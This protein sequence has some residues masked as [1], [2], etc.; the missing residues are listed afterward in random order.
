MK[1]GY[2]LIWKLSGKT[3]KTPLILGSGTL[4]ENKD[5]LVKC[6]KYGAGAVI[7]RSLR[8]E[9]KKRKIFNPAYYI[10]KNYMLN[11]DN[12]NVVPWDYWL[13]KV[14][15]IEKY[16]KF[17][18]S[19]SAR[20]PDDCKKIVSAFEKKNP[21][22]FYEINFS[23]PH[24][25]KLYGEI[26]YADAEKALRYAKEETSCPVFLKLSLENINIGKL[27]FFEKEKLID[28]LVL[29]NSIGHGM[30]IDI[31]NKKPYLESV[32]GGMSGKAIKL[33]VLAAIYELK[34]R[35]NTPIIGV[36]GIENAEDVI[37]YIILGCDAVQIYTKA[38][39]DGLE[40]FSKISK[41]LEK[42]FLE[43]KVKNIEELKGTLW[44]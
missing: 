30:K 14:E 23:C 5:N 19:I 32:V 43:M 15:E 18:A 22:S 40:I 13:D 41:D 33:L 24:S 35:L 6:L 34:Q 7:N 2:V 36:G 25:A 21:P 31:K 20:N 28:A 1:T 37:E 16:G 27:L 26:S 9:S 42:L 38:H 11:A 29:S 39:T 8:M 4:G 44:K 17:I 10:E 3:L 12:Q